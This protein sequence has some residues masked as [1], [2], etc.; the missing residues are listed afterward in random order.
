M[1]AQ[2]IRAIHHQ[3]VPP[4]QQS[5]VTANNLWHFVASLCEIQHLADS[6]KTHTHDGGPV[7]SSSAS[8]V[9]LGF[10]NHILKPRLPSLL[11]PLFLP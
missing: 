1:D 2:T 11:P 7:H 5:L 6:L 3:H 9:E 4:V 8:N 10:K